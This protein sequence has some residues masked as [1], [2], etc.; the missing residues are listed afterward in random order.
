[1]SATNAIFVAS[2]LYV[3][4]MLNAGPRYAPAAATAIVPEVIRTGAA[5]SSAGI[6]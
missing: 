5:E 1:M 2:G 3:R 4:G 6:V